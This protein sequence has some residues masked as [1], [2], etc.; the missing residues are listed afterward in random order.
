MSYK[1]KNANEFR[2]DLD[3]YLIENP[4]HLNYEEALLSNFNSHNLSD[5]Y[6]LF[7]DL[8]G[9]N[10]SK[11]SYVKLKS[12]LKNN[13]SIASNQIFTLEDEENDSIHISKNIHISRLLEILK[14]KYI[15][16]VK[17]DSIK[18]QFIDEEE[19]Y[20]LFFLK[21]KNINR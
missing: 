17:E 21:S 3:N 6:K 15:S 14:D 5:L 16:Y 4:L 8:K 12:I 13:F 11:Q 20:K 7:L 2:K 10:L 1:L 18:P 9:S 19:L